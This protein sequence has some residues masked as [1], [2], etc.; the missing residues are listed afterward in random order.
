MRPSCQSAMAWPCSAA[1][2][3]EVTARVFSPLR[4]ASVALRNA[5]TGVCGVTAALSGDGLPSSDRLG[6]TPKVSAI[7]AAL[8]KTL[9]IR[10]ARGLAGAARVGDRAVQGRA[11]LL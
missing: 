11:D 5:S 4:N 1:Y 10:I 3:S 2:C 9:N 8:A 6:P 7:T